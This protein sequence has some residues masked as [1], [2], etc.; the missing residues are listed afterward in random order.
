MDYVALGIPD[1]PDIVKNPMDFGTI[2]TNIEN[3]VIQTR[4][5]FAANVRL[6]FS[7][8]F[9]YNKPTDDVYV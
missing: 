7:N 4:E 6:V 5:D 8:A 1:Y 9:L 2:L 3:R